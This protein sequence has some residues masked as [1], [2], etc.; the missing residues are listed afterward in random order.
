MARN[1]TSSNS[2]NDQSPPA[3]T[4]EFVSRLLLVAASCALIALAVPTG[5]VALIEGIGAMPLPFN[6]HVVDQ[7]LPGIFKLH[8]LASG[9]ALMLIPLVIA[10]RGRRE[11]HRPLGRLTAVLVVAGALTSFPVAYESTSVLPARL[12]F[13]AQGIV[14]LGL[15]VAG[16]AA[17]RRKDLTRH[18]TL[19]LAMSAVASGA[20]WVRLT[21]AVATSYELPFDPIYA[22][23]TWLG[24]LIPL[25]LVL[26]L[27]PAR[28][29][30]RRKASRPALA[31]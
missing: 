21:T 24:W 9:A 15:I 1:P 16:V 8:M 3:A 30:E 14:W 20:I 4:G 27:A 11:W 12:G 25:A 13:A 26:A 23:A 6:L 28:R 5:V 19:M 31:T 18:A 2:D 22:C 29:P 7:R 10:T 17:I